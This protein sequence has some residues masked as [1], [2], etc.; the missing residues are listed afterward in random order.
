MMARKAEKWR[1]GW[2]QIQ[3]TIGCLFSALVAMWDS[4]LWVAFQ[5]KPEI[6]FFC[7]DQRCRAPMMAAAT[8]SDFKML[9]THQKLQLHSNSHFRNNWALLVSQD[10]NSKHKNFCFKSLFWATLSVIYL[11]HSY[12]MGTK[13]VSPRVIIVISA[14]ILKP[15]SPKKRNQDRDSGFSKLGFISSL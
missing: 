6:V 10:L 2:F 14:E 15:T 12:L 5:L 4:Q 7:F 3:Q 8:G 11:G 1:I 9:K 13:H